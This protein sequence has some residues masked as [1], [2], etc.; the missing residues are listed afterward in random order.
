MLMYPELQASLDGE[1]ATSR[2]EE[3]SGSGLYGDL[4]S[5]MDGSINRALFYLELWELSKSKRA[6]AKIK[7]EEQGEYILDTPQD[8]FLLERVI[9]EG[10]ELEFR[11]VDKE[12]YLN[13]QSREYTLEYKERLSEVEG[14]SS[15]N[16]ELSLLFGAERL[17]P[18]FIKGEL[19]VESHKI[20][21]ECLERFFK[22]IES[23][24]PLKKEPASKRQ[25]I[26]KIGE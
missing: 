13:E 6:T 10:N 20:A 16:R 8:L 21:C 25:T 24:S 5:S 12:I 18:Y 26:Y 1:L 22:G 9:S 3:L 14:T 11:V 2:L 7:K 4:I 17:I 15:H 19:Y 23:L